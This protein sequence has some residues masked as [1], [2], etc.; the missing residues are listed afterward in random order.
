[1]FI[2][3]LGGISYAFGA[4]TIKNDKDLYDKVALNLNDLGYILLLTFSFSQLV[5]V[6]EQ[7]QI[8][9]VL[10]ASLANLMN[11]LNFQGIPLII[12]S[13][14]IISLSGLILPS[15]IIKWKIFSPIMIPTF[16]KASIS[17]Q[18]GQF[19]FRAAD[20]MTKGFSIFAGGFI[21]YVI[22]LN[23][24]NTEEHPVTFKK[25]LDFILP[26]AGIIII[27]WISLILFWYILGLPVGPFVNAIL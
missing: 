12:M 21:I 22:Y 1:M 26:Y 15:T 24:Y 5:S 9:L 19:I 25:A 17:P 16:I 27:T 7:T 13:M 11:A 6:F 10:T 8:D 23:I 18:F 14:I 4:E 20:S 3:T 2:L